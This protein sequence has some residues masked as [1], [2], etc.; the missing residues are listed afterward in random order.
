MALALWDTARWIPE[1]TLLGHQSVIAD[2]AFSAD[3]KRLASAGRDNQCRLW[4]VE[5]GR[6]VARFPG[7]AVDLAPDGSAIAV[8]GEYTL[9]GRFPKESSVTIYRAP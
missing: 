6:E 8:G 7:M 3:G 2:F 1:K 5:F 4:D 9:N